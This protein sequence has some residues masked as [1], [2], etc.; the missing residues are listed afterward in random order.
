MCAGSSKVA[1]TRRDRRI[2]SERNGS[3]KACI[4]AEAADED[5]QLQ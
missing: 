1:L 4:V 3:T 2:A 5:T